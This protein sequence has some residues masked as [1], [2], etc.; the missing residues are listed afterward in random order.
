MKIPELEQSVGLNPTSPAAPQFAPPVQ[1]AFGADIGQ[2]VERLGAATQGAGAQIAERA[3]ERNRMVKEQQAFDAYTSYGRDIQDLGHKQDPDTGNPVLDPQTNKPQGLLDRQLSDAHGITAEFDQKAES[4]K[5]NYLNGLKDPSQ[6]ALF[7]QLAARHAGAARESIIAHEAREGTM[8]YNASA[9]AS[10][11]AVGQSVV[12]TT[13]ADALSKAVDDA[14][15]IQHASLVRS[16]VRDQGVMDQS[17]AQVAAA[18]AEKPIN[19]QL[20]NGSWKVAGQLLDRVR[21]RLPQDAVDHLQ[22]AISGRAFAD[23]R[24]SVW[25]TL[26]ARPE[27]RLQDGKTFDE[28]KARALILDDKAFPLADPVSGK[29]MGDE[30]RQQLAGFVKAMA[31]E[32]AHNRQRQELAANTQFTNDVVGARAQGTGLEAALKMAADP[33]YGFD[34][35]GAG[36]GEKFI[37]RLYAEADAKSD[38]E[39]LIALHKGLNDG[40]V[41]NADQIREQFNAGLLSKHDTVSLVNALQHGETQP[42]KEQWNS[43]R[44]ELE[45]KLPDKQSRAT[46]AAALLQ[47]Q[48]EKGVT[49]PADLQKLYK[50]NLETV[51]TG[52]PGFFRVFGGK[53]AAYYKV[54]EGVQQNQELVKAAGGTEA[55]VDLAQ[56]LGGPDSFAPGSPSSRAVLALLKRG[57]EPKRIIP[58]SIDAVIKNHPDWI[59]APKGQEK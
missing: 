38:P 9:K 39:T 14:T 4:L 58:A 28:E 53:T 57:A 29:P 41:T 24:Q 16:G 55:A 27:M 20:A 49:D 52:A 56:R 21:D 2:A 5:K 31:G 6:Q 45:T 42:M 26:A 51:P 33:K 13:D 30:Q 54:A 47:Q 34:A 10:I 18:I 40:S 3:I 48:Y 19:E 35:S 8:A 59:T 44:A 36:E 46:F 43:I 17:K 1:G 22:G 23:T 11:D 50:A 12:G 37:K 32:E 7:M 15:G 25:E